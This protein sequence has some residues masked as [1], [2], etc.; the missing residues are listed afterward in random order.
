[1]PRPQQPKAPKTLARPRRPRLLIEHGGWPAYR[2]RVLNDRRLGPLRDWLLGEADRLLTEPPQAYELDDSGRL[3]TPARFVLMRTLVLAQAFQLT[4]DARFAHR[5]RRELLHS[6]A[7]PDWGPLHLL[8]T[9]ELCTAVA[10][11]YDWLYDTLSPADR[12][13]LLTALRD[14]G[15]ERMPADHW[16]WTRENNWNQVCCGGATL[17]ALILEEHEPE[18]AEQ[19]LKRARTSIVHGMAA[20]AP[21]GIC[22]EGAGYWSYG[23]TYNALMFSA[24]ETAHGIDPD[25]LMPDPLRRSAV[26][27]GMLEGP[28]G[29]WW[30]FADSFGQNRLEPALLWFARVSE[31]PELA[32]GVF[33]QIGRLDA[34]L[35][36][37]LASPVQSWLMPLALV[38][39]VERE[40]GAAVTALP[41]AWRGQGGVPLAILR[42]SEDADD[43]DAAYVAIKGGSAQ[44]SHAHM[45]SGSFVVDL[46]GQRWAIDLGGESYVQIE[47]AFKPTGQSLWDMT[48]DSPRWSLLRYSNRTHNTLTIDG[49][50]QDANAKAEITHTGLDPEPF[51]VLDLSPVYKSSATG[52]SRTVRLPGP[53]TVVI[54]DELAGVPGDQ[55]VAW[56][57]LTDAVVTRVSPRTLCLTKAGRSVW[58]HNGCPLATPFDV[59]LLDGQRQPQ[60]SPNP[61][62]WLIR[63]YSPGTQTGRHR[64]RVVLNSEPAQVHPPESDALPVCL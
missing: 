38:W 19:A 25:Q 1:M 50:N 48:Q 54:D 55:N 28:S 12:R 18:L 32:R 30:A 8:D 33:R 62:V 9:A 21:D 36:E 34:H 52:V 61:G 46:L 24:L 42:G 58:L 13:T 64:F 53:R 41:R 17:A 29:Q 5:A 26:V 51:A 7:Y 57:W 56:A 63:L 59:Q 6:T 15:L 20:Y 40:K 3:L 44:E 39:P 22:V 45:D 23:A 4:E 60:E 37:D 11:G 47:S 2:E 14:K 31:T 10:L 27:R 35:R 43:L 16:C 49:Q